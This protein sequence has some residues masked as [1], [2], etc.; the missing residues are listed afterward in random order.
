MRGIQSIGL[1]FALLSL[2]PPMIMKSGRMGPEG[3]GLYLAFIGAPILLLSAVMVIP[4]SILLLIPSVR[5]KYGMTRGWLWL[6]LWLWLANL[7]FSFALIGV[8]IS[9]FFAKLFFNR[10]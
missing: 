9:P 3:A 5:V 1:L 2:V 8:V 7:T 10:V 6:W 4:S